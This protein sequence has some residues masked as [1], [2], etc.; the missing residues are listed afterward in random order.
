MQSQIT[1]SFTGIIKNNIEAQQ[2]GLPAYDSKEVRVLL[3][4]TS[5]K[6][7]GEYKAIFLLCGL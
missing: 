4:F 7:W 1:K 3:S 6:N 2:Q 5:A